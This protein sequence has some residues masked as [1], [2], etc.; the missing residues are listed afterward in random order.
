MVC[1]SPVLGPRS[2]LARSRSGKKFCPGVE[3][4][5]LRSSVRATSSSARSCCRCGGGN[6]EGWR[7]EAR[8]VQCYSLIFVFSWLR[9]LMNLHDKFQQSSG[10]RDVPQMQFST[11]VER[12]CCRAKSSS[13][14]QAENNGGA[15]LQ[16]IMVV[17]VPVTM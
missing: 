7:G 6:E 17:Y 15:A 1:S 8:L 3:W 9:R 10:V 5:R 11:V 12:P 16:S 13:S 2:L 4:H 14:S